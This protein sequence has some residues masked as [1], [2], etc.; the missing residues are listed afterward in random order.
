MK[1]LLKTLIILAA[2]LSACRSERGSSGPAPT[3][4]PGYFPL[5]PGSTWVYEGGDDATGRTFTEGIRA[6]TVLGERTY[7]Q[8]VHFDAVRGKWTRLFRRSGD[9]VFLLQSAGVEEVFLIEQVGAAWSVSRSDGTQSETED[10]TVVNSSG[11]VDVAGR[12]FKDV[13]LVHSTLNSRFKG[14]NLVAEMD[15]YFAR[16][17]GLIESRQVVESGTGFRR[18]SFVVKH[19]VVEGL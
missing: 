7:A 5:T 1:T 3:F 16:N 18:E 8:R 19:V 4:V 14:E 13:V 10:F 12:T 17:V 6:D 9:T 15:L 11:A 2:A